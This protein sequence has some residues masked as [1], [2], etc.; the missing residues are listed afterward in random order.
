ML[1]H[2]QHFD[3]EP[4]FERS[5]LGGVTTYHSII[6]TELAMKALVLDIASSYSTCF[7]CKVENKTQ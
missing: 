4:Q 2:V 7:L 1:S 5:S 6:C 3:H